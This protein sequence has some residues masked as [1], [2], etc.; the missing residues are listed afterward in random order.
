MH[1]STHKG[2][3]LSGVR[4]LVL[5]MLVRLKHW[6][7]GWANNVFA[8][9]CISLMCRF[10]LRLFICSFV[11]HNNKWRHVSFGRDVHRFYV[12]LV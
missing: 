5:H 6:V 8:S 10:V 11:Q 3:V 9:V 4:S 1:G 2:M 7:V 12:S